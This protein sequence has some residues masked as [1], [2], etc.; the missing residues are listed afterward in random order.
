MTRQRALWLGGGLAVAAIII[1]LLVWTTLH[2]VSD[3]VTGKA[4]P[5]A[6]AQPLPTSPASSIALPVRVPI[7]LL[8]T[9]METAVPRT[10]WS[11]DEPGKTC[12][13]GGR[14]K[15]FGSKVKV[16][17]DIKC[18]IVGTVLRGPIRLSSRGSTLHLELPISAEISAR[19]IG[20]II[21]QETATAKAVVTA[22]V[23]PYLLPD[24]HLAARIQL[25]YDWR[26]EPGV[27]ILGQ[28]IRLTEKVDEKLA[29][30]LARAETELAGKL[31]ALPIRD[32]LA[33]VWE[34]GFTVESINRRNPQAW[35]RLTPQRLDFAGISVE[36]DQLRIDAVLDAIAE[37]KLGPAPPRPQPTPMPPIGTSQAGTGFTMSIAVLSDFATLEAVLAKALG[38]LSA[39]GIT[40]P[41]QGRVSVTFGRPTLYA[42]GGGRLALGIDVAARG[43]RDMLDTRGRVWLTARAETAPDSERVLIR[44]IQL[45]SGGSDDVQLPVLVAVAGSDA[46]RE[47]IE[48]A[49]IQDLTRD[50]R[51]LLTRIDKALTDIKVGKFR[52]SAELREVHHG[53]VLVLGQGL[54]LPVE[55]NGT[56]RLDYGR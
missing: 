53:R 23:K 46:L 29:P 11:I 26:Q 9:A 42:T 4:P 40:L 51:K 14:V 16:T 6:A 2:A 48:E 39:R 24:G 30:M 27:T 12:V 13:Q 3:A 36:G 22:D 43:E 33:G 37:V 25:N 41:D 32:R 44:D 49:L 18:R 5:R 7:A 19:D 47:T 54:H 34:S 28:H 55:A 17:P 10:L 31:A 50:Y 8:Q 45:I 38:K 20:G 21:R 1:A 35:L 56:A 52:L 15:L